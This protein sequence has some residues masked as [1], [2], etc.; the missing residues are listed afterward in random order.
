MYGPGCVVTL[1]LVVP[2]SNWFWCGQVKISGTVAFI[3]TASLPLPCS[4]RDDKPS[5]RLPV[6][7]RSASHPNP[8]LSSFGRPCGGASIRAHFFRGS[9]PG[10]CQPL[11]WQSDELSLALSRRC[12]AFMP[13]FV[14]QWRFAHVFCLTLRRGLRRLRFCSGDFLSPAS[15]LDASS[16]LG[17]GRYSAC[18]RPRIRLLLRWHS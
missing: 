8:H 16:T 13:G 5:L 4:V 6:L 11:W 1:L 9:A 10:S 2:P 3:K 15:E 17:Q 18:R 12:V 7:G 14:L